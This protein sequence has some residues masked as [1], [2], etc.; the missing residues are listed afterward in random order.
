M[1]IRIGVFDYFRVEEWASLATMP[2]FIGRLKRREDIGIIGVKPAGIWRYKRH[3]LCYR[4]RLNLLG[5]RGC[6]GSR[7]TLNDNRGSAGPF[8][9]GLA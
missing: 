2:D 1:A 7:A 3:V 5:T 4:D 8:M 6:N 9:S